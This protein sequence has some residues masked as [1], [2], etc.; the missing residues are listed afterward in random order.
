MP[1]TKKHDF[2]KKEIIAGALV[3]GAIAVLA[4][5]VLLIQGWRPPEETREYAAQFTKIIGLKNGAEVRFGGMIAG[6]VTAISPDPDDRDKIR[7]AVAVRPELPVN[8]ESIATIETI[9]LTSDFHLEISTGDA[10][11]PLLQPGGMLKSLTKSGGFVD[12]PNMDGLISGSEDLIGDL[13]DFLG[14]KEVKEKEEAGEGELASMAVIMGDMRNFLG[15]EDARKEEEAGGREMPKI[16]RIMQD[17]RDFLG[18]QE[19]REEEA[20]GEGEGLV[21]LADITGSVGGLF[22]R[23]QPQLDQIVEKIPAIEDSAKELLDELN[24]LLSDNKENLDSTLDS[25]ASLLEKLNNEID[26]MMAE[27]KNVLE[28]TDQL[29]GGLADAVEQNRPSLED[30]LGDLGVAAQNLN[31]FMQQLNQQPQSVIWGK[32][33]QGRR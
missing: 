10:E 31:L 17:L 22:D 32:P 23:Y 26:S 28:N 21:A 25:V 15:V 18:V 5:F 19:A 24:S 3:F 7:V 20:A 1:V 11:A 16:T 2:T 12:I 8:E 4:C 9:S 14:V 29:T 6:K 30:L 13:R 27:I 33:E